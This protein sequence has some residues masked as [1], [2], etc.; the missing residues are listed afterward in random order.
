L[1]TQRTHKYLIV[2]AGI[3]SQAIA[4]YLLGKEDTALVTFFER[5]KDALERTQQRTR[6]LI[7]PNAALAG[8]VQGDVV[9]DEAK[10]RLLMSGACDVV[11]SAARYSLNV[12]LTKMAIDAKVHM[13]D[14]GGNNDVVAE[15]FALGDA[16]KEAGVAILPDSGICPGAGSVLTAH[17]LKRFPA[18]KNVHVYCGGL[19]QEKHRTSL[20]P[21]QYALSFDPSGLI[22][23]YDVICEI[24]RLGKR[25]QVQPL[26]EREE[27]DFPGIGKLVA[28]NTSGGISTMVETYEGRLKTLQYKT[29]RY[30]ALREG[31]L[32][33]WH[34]MKALRDL[35]WFK[36]KWTKLTVDGHPV[37]PRQVTEEMFRQTLPRD[38]PDQLALAVCLDDGLGNHF[39]LD[40]LDKADP[41]TGLSAMQRTTGFSAA[42]EAWM[43]ATGAIT[44]RGTL[45]HELHVPTTEFIHEWDECGITLH[46]C[47]STNNVVALKP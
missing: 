18:A 38:I 21:L 46:Q 39:T 17:G 42:I 19:P 23:E 9:K 36:E 22:N 34:Y 41:V 15:Q 8:F 43:L 40:I 12:G 45:K 3:Q 32:D 7:K 30:P 1:T 44:A 4:H 20:G 47:L 35:G 24:I 5:D 6:H 28:V 33:H 10:L 27:I 16:A 25:S 2:G 14:L 29:L 31:D 37:T 26:T 11:V 13:V